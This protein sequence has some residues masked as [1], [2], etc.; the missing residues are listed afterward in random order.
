MCMPLCTWVHA[1]VHAHAYV[2]MPMHVHVHYMLL[3]YTEYCPPL[4]L[5]GGNA[6]VYD[7]TAVSL[8]DGSYRVGTTAT[9]SCPDSFS[10]EGGP[11]VRTCMAVV[12]SIDGLGMWDG[13][14]LTCDGKTRMHLSGTI[15]TV[16]CS[17]V[18]QI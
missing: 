10:L 6:I 18:F 9:H 3:V 2:C 5:E 4:D 11:D 1:Y 12:G 16:I 15:Y 13:S 17:L 14:P 8:P 7:P